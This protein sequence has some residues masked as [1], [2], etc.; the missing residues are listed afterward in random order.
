MMVSFIDIGSLA[1]LILQ[2]SRCISIISESI[3]I[4]AEARLPSKRT[5][6]GIVRIVEGAL[7]LKNSSNCPIT[8]NSPSL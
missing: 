1:A 3:A 6:S 4:H 2:T 5:D 7:F 8:A